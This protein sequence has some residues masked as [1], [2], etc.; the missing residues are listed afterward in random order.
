[1]KSA[2]QIL[3]PLSL[4]QA[5]KAYATAEQAETLYM[6]MCAR[7]TQLEQHLAIDYEDD[8]DTRLY[9]CNEYDRTLRFIVSI[10]FAR[11]IRFML[12]PIA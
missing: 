10:G 5:W 12:R 1:M 4:A 3:Q 8:S 6:M 9:W 2:A 7:L 11:R